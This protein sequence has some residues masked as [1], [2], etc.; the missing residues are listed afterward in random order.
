MSSSK[1]SVLS[2]V[3]IICSSWNP[4]ISNLKF[5]FSSKGVLWS[6]AGWIGDWYSEPGKNFS[7]A[8]FSQLKLDYASKG[9]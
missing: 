1:N 8:L 6:E 7:K 4:I 9:L 3:F 2:D 5:S